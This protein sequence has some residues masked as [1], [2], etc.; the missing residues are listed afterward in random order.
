M[1]HKKINL[2]ALMPYGLKAARIAIEEWEKRK[3]GD[4]QTRVLLRIVAKITVEVT[5]Y[6]QI[7]H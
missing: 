6:Q 7:K 4:S 5:K 3:P 2:A 1:Q